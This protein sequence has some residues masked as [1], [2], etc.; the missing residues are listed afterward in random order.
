[1]VQSALKTHE[2][3]QISLLALLRCAKHFEART[4]IMQMPVLFAE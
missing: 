3:P 2:A 4:P 1:L